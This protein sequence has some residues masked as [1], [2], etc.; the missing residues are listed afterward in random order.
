M[1][2]TWNCVRQL[3]RLSTLEA[4]LVKS[5]SEKR[6][7]AVYRHAR[8]FWLIRR[9]ETKFREPESRHAGFGMRR[10]VYK[11]SECPQ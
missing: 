1:I 4:F 9:L 7:A 3:R 6:I 5:A 8:G 2:R 11:P 10:K